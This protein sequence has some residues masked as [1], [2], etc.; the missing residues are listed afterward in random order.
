MRKK[1]TEGRRSFLK[2]GAFGLAGLAVL[3]SVL[4]RDSRAQTGEASAVTDTTRVAKKHALMTRTLGRTGLT[5]PILS[6]G[7]MTTDNPEVLKAA[8][9]AGIVHIDTAHAYQRG[10]N[11]EMIGEIVKGRPR[12]SFVIAT[13]V[14]GPGDSRTGMFTKD[15]TSEM[16]AERFETSLKRL[17]LDYVDI[18]YIHD[19]VRK[20]A[21]TYEPFLSVLEKL[22]K[23]GKTRFIG[24]TTHGNEPEVI[25]AAVE[26][27][28]HDVVLTAYNFRQPHIKEMDEAM[29]AAAKA[30][31]GIVA[32]KTQAGIYWDRERKNPINMKAALKWVLRNENVHTAIPGM[33]TF[34]QLETNLSAVEEFSLTPEEKEDLKLGQRMGMLGLYCRQCGTCVS[35]CGRNLEIPTLM[36]SYMYVYGYRNLAAA[37]D[38]METVALSRVPCD[39]CSTC[40]VNCPMGFDVKGRIQDVAR[41][42]NIPYDFVA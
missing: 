39:S 3:P 37:K 26:S 22:K 36:R 4:T 32:M 13:K 20:E 8:L 16:F 14:S 33:T 9:E 30:G 35:Q 10:R 1:S 40:S 18:L 27:K 29:A 17:G 15:A 19:V 31:V 21:V 42:Q 5:L 12:D 11:E 24:V 25:R 7:A 38:A 23:E 34:D 41:I 2:K 28:V 6:I